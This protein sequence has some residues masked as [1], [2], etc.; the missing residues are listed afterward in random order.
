VTS[1]KPFFIVTFYLLNYTKQL[2]CLVVMSALFCVLLLAVLNAACSTTVT[3]D[4]DALRVL[5]NV[6]N[7]DQWYNMYPPYAW[8]FNNVSD[9][10]GDQWYGV[11]CDNCAG[12]SDICN[13]TGLDLDITNLYGSLPEELCNA[14]Q[15]NSLSFTFNILLGNIPEC[16]TGDLSLTYLSLLHNSLSGDIPPFG[17]KSQLAYLDL[18][19]NYFT[20]TI[21]SSL[22]VLSGTL[23]YL[24]LNLNSLKGS[25]PVEIGSLAV[26]SSVNIGSN[27]LNGTLPSAM[28]LLE[29]L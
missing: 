15:L 14:S 16:I 11:T 8:V 3:R 25:I 21:P 24:A 5:F 26:L 7:G 17:P 1:C 2:I 9:P 20:S 10:C 12:P 19:Q 13:V 29:E 18:S 22:G 23:T 4:I 6:T 28:F 27:R